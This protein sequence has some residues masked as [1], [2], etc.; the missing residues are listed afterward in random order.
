[1][2][3]EIATYAAARRLDAGLRERLEQL[4]LEAGDCVEELLALDPSANTLRDLIRL[5]EEICAR[6]GIEFSALLQSPEVRAV[7]TRENASRKEKQKLLRAAL[8][9]RR[10]P[11]VQ[12]IRRQLEELRTSIRSECGVAIEYPQDFE[13]DSVSLS[14]SARSVEELQ[15]LAKKIEAAAAHPDMTKLFNA[16]HGDY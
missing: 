7:F 8:E 14:L 12:K 2:R 4:E 15:E 10:Y 5:S 6:D 13:G 3:T 9:E 1:M 11:E 16:L